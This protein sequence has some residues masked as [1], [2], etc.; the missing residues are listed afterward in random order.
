MPTDDIRVSYILPLNFIFFFCHPDSNLQD[1]RSAP[2]KSIYSGHKMR[3]MAFISIPVALEAIGFET[4]Q[5]IGNIKHALGHRWLALCLCSSIRFFHSS[6]IIIQGLKKSEIW[7]WFSNLKRFCQNRATCRQ[8]KT[9]LW[10]A[11]DWAMTPQILL[12]SGPA[13]LRSLWRKAPWKIV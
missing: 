9:K 12:I 5:H 11:N 8:F 2:V 13:T 1:G 4:G 3:N 7:P 10:N 6:R